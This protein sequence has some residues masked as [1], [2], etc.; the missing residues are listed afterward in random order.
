[1]P[2]LIKPILIFSAGAIIAIGVQAL[3]PKEH[4][5]LVSLSPDARYRV[6]MVEVPAF[7]DRNFE[8]RLEDLE[9]DVTRTIFAS[10]DEGRPTGSEQIVWSRDSGRF[11]LLGRRFSAGLR[12][13]ET[14][15]IAAYLMY[16]VP[17]GEA[18][19][20]ADVRQC[21]PLSV[22]AVRAI[23]W[24]LGLE[25]LATTPYAGD[26]TNSAAPGVSR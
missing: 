25:G 13:P 21:Q 2:E 15:E 26:R 8:L 23:A 14:G 24:E 22:E 19:C 11:L 5:T 4:V 1:M 17:T 20:L 18:W 12:L 7:I 10:P 16:D 3:L 6:R 9:G